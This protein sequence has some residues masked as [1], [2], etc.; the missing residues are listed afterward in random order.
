MSIEPRLMIKVTIKCLTT[1]AQHMVP[2]DSLDRQIDC[3]PNS[4]A[5]K[6]ATIAF[7]IDTNIDQVEFR[8]FHANQHQI[9][10]HEP[11]QW[12]HFSTKNV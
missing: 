3:F 9:H 11:M 10:R 7:A 8:S 4:F 2:V 1:N 6:I 12:L 5:S